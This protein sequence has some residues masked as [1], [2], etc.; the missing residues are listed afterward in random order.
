MSSLIQNL[1]G[2]FNAEI[3]TRQDALDVTQAH[4]R[5]ATRELA[6][7]RKQIALWQARCSEADQAAHQLANLERAAAAEDGFDWSGRGDLDGHDARLGAPD[8][9]RWTRFAPGVPAAP[10]YP[11]PV[12]AG[13]GDEADIP[14]PQGA[15]VATLVRLRRMKIWSARVEALLEERARRLQGADLVKEFQCRK[16]VALCTG[17]PVDK[18]EQV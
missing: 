14:L 13:A 15:D 8:A 16:I 1:S 5:A 18:V 2:E 7:Q 6:E 4:L 10:T 12:D 17:H 11:P 3:K 9:L